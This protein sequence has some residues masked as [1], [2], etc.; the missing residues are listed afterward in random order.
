MNIERHLLTEDATT[1]LI[2]KLV[3]REKPMR[4]WLADI[5][6][7][8]RVLLQENWAQDASWINIMLTFRRN[9][10]QIP[11]PPPP[12]PKQETQCWWVRMAQFL[13]CPVDLFE[14]NTKVTPSAGCSFL[15]VC[16]LMV[17]T[18]CKWGRRVINKQCQPLGTTTDQFRIQK[19]TH[20]LSVAS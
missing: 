5:S 12:P 16:F 3:C 15:Y 11:P 17:G 2:Q 6:C 18:Y 19:I 1:T 7:S 13:F 10:Q 14:N 9:L 4:K 8:V 20:W